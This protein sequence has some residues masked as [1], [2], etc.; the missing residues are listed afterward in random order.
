MWVWSLSVAPPPPCRHLTRWYSRVSIQGK[1]QEIAD[2]LK[3]CM[4]AALS[5]YHEANQCLPER[6]IVFRDG[7][8]DGQINI[9]QQFEVP[10]IKESFTMFGM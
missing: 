8:G 6:V 4:K 1:G 10:Q 3:V 9:V 2:G 5:K 7:V